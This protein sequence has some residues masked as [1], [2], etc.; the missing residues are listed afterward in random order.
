MDSV[1]IVLLAQCLCH[2]S[3]A[4]PNHKELELCRSVFQLSGAGVKAG[5]PWATFGLVCVNARHPAPRAASPDDKLSLVCFTPKASTRCCK[6]CTCSFVG[7]VALGAALSKRGDQGLLTW[8]V[9]KRHE[10]GD[11]TGACE[12]GLMSFVPPTCE[13]VYRTTLFHTSMWEAKRRGQRYPTQCHQARSV[14]V[15]NLS[16]VESGQPPKSTKLATSSLANRHVAFSQDGLTS[17]C[18]V[19]LCPTHLQLEGLC[20]ILATRRTMKES[21]VGHNRVSKSPR[22]AKKPRGLEVLQRV[23][24]RRRPC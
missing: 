4:S 22:C 14:Q 8:F 19:T 13:A 17:D 9:A 6:V 23:A 3:R 18:T 16:P 1:P 12:S 5:V 15:T 21:A 24:L 10:C 7:C 20:A 11:T 2:A